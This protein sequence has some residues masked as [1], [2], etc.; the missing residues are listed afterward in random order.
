[1]AGETGVVTPG[2]QQVRFAR[3]MGVMTGS[4]PFHLQGGML[5][6]TLENFSHFLMAF[7]TEVVPLADENQF[8]DDAVPLVAAFTVVVLEGLMSMTGFGLFL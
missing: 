8:P 1:M 7:E 5:E 6:F 2:G 4:T 3:P